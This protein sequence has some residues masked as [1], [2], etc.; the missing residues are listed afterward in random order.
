[1]EEDKLIKETEKPCC[2]CIDNPVNEYSHI[3]VNYKGPKPTTKKDWVD[4]DE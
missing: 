4:S 3:P 2:E 1:M